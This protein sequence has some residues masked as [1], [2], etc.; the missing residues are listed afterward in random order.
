MR[1]LALLWKSPRDAPGITGCCESDRRRVDP[2][3]DRYR[4]WRRSGGSGEFVQLTVHT[5]SIETYY[6]ANP[7]NPSEPCPHPQ[8]AYSQSRWHRGYSTS[9][10]WRQSTSTALVPE[11]SPQSQPSQRELYVRPLRTAA[12]LISATQAP[13][14]AKQLMQ[15]VEGSQVHLSW[16]PGATNGAEVDQ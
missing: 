10:R 16:T 13:E 7:L 1:S 9:S 4:V 15:T 6:Q 14:S 5:G 3:V 11:V 12:H 8:C 2:P